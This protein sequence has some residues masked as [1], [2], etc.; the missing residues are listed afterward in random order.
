MSSVHAIVE[1][2]PA[3]SRERERIKARRAKKSR[4]T[5]MSQAELVAGTISEGG[6]SSSGYKR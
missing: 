2:Y 3:R 5:E 1:R 4:G 6:A